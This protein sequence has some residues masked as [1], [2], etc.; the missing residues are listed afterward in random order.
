ME[1]MPSS[2]KDEIMKVKVFRIVPLIACCILAVSLCAVQG[3]AASPFAIQKLGALRGGSSVARAIIAGQVVGSSGEPQ[4]ENKAF[5]WSAGKLTPLGFLPGGDYSSAQAISRNSYVAGMANTETNVHAFL[6]NP[7]SGMHDLGTLPGDNASAAFGLND[8]REVVGY[9]SGVNGIRAAMWTSGG[10]IQLLGSLPADN[11]SQAHAINNSGQV[12]GVSGDGN[13]QRAFLW[14]SKAGMQD[15]GFLP[16]DSG[17]IALAIN[18]A[19]EIVGTSSGPNGTHA[20]IWTNG[21]MRPLGEMAGSPFSQA[22]DINAAGQVV[23]VVHTN[24]GPRAFLWSRE[25]GMQDLNEMISETDIVLL[26]ALAIDDNGQIVT[27]GLEAADAAHTA[28]IDHQA[29]AGPTSVFVLTKV[30]AH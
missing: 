5:I 23:G 22:V 17:S 27:L 24:L 28:E 16:G 13:R 25:R 6:W 8:H 20:F 15:L 11:F 10:R 19:G 29:H 30:G 18:E 4:D 26:E 1:N 12:V 2:L 9:S 21:S 7:R 14:S 3:L